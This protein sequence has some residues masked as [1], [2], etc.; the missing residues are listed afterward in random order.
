MKV[1][2]WIENSYTG[3]TNGRPRNDSNFSV[4]PNRLANSWQGNQYYLVL[5]KTLAQIDS[6]NFGGRFDT[7]LGN[8][9]QFTKSYGLF[10]RE[11]VN[12]HFAGVDLPQIFA[13]VHLPILTKNGFDIR[14]GRFYSPAGFENVQAIKRPLLSVPYL[15]NYTPFTLF[16]VL[17]TLHL[18]ERTNIFNGAVNGW[19]RWIDQNYRYSY[20]GGFSY[21]SRDLEVGRHH[22]RPDR[23]RPVAPVRPGQLAV[24][25]HRR[26]HQRRPPGQG[27]PVLRGELADLPVNRRHAQLDRKFTE[28]A[29][30]FFVHETNVPGSA[31]RHRQPRVGLVRRGPL[32][33]V[34]LHQQGP[35]GLPGRD[36]P[37]PGRRAPPARPTT[38]TR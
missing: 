30:V 13:E 25:A 32:V 26:A 28:A 14:G 6:V 10:D 19:D 12:G 11:F 37:R 1:Y 36:L 35:G 33:S 22:D 29:E 24:H 9:W 17:T 38:T 34:Q 8:D 4:F 5:E 16:G 23:P 7:L 21:N 2:G 3:N 27:Q 20:L 31:Q 15:F 18:N